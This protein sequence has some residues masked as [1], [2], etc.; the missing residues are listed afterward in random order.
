MRFCA[1]LLAAI[2]PILAADVPMDILEA[3]KKG[4]NKEIEAL[5]A[6]GADLEA[7]DEKAARR[8]CSPPNTAVPPPCAC[9]STKAPSP[10]PATTHRW[11]AYMLALLAPSGGVVHTTHEAVLKLLPQPKRFRLAITASWAPERALQFLFHAPRR[12]D[13]THAR[14]SPRRHGHR[15]PAAFRRLAG[16]D[17][18]AI[19]SADAR[20]NTEISERPTPEDVDAVLTL[21]VEPGVACVQQEDQL[22][23]MIH[24]TLNRPKDQAPL[25]EKTFGT[26]VKTGMR[27]EV[28]T[29]AEPARSALCGVGKVA[30][31]PPLL[32]RT[33]CAAPGLIQ[34]TMPVSA[35]KDPR[36]ALGRNPDRLTLVERTALA[37]K[38]VALEIYTPET[39]PFRRIEAIGDSIDACIRMLRERGLDPRHFEYSPLGPPY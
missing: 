28:A 18:I 8:S 38:M 33:D 37:G 39:F 4:K 19:V 23:M 10:T 6:K 13:P 5:L 22:S 29:N 14:N 34:F 17:L 35:A 16:R 11:N 21:Q 1:V 25:L 24:A 36:Q 31:G 9:C 12:D 32:G 3:A 20:G 2:F 27:G 7:R 26:G 15:S 30:G